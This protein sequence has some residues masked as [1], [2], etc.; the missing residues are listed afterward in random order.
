MNEKTMNDGDVAIKSRTRSVAYIGLSIAIIAVCAWVTVPIGPVPFTL[1][2][3]AIPL[4]IAVLPPIQAVS[5]VYLYVII[6][7]IGVPIFSGFKGGIGV[8]LGPTGGFLIGYLIGVVLAVLF[9]SL[10]RQ[11]AKSSALDIAFV[12]VAG[13][14]FT[15]CAY[16]VG[17]I[18]YSVVANVGMQ[19]AFLVS[20][21]PFIIPDLVKVIVA[22]ICAQGV[23]R[24]IR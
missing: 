13:I 7:A 22:A 17:C 4:V 18:Q 8:L 2:M 11:K 3:L 24:V 19:Q 14:I 5:A 6:G 21:A 20:C 16:V 9:L 23:R 15:A 10:V 12:I 1:Q